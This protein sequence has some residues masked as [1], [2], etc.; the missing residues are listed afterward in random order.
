MKIVYALTSEGGDVYSQM[1][2]LSVASVRLSNP[3]A[4]VTL[5]TDTLTLGRLREKCDPLLTEVDSVKSVAAPP[6]DA[7]YRSRYV[8]TSLRSIAKGPFLFLDADTIVRDSLEP[9]FQVEADLAAAVNHS[10]DSFQEQPADDNEVLQAMEWTTG[11]DYYLN[12]GVLFF[13][14]TPAA[15]DLGRRWHECWHASV[16]RLGRHVDQPAMNHALHR[17]RAR[18]AILPHRFNAQILVAPRVAMDAAVWHYYWSFKRPPMTA[19]GVLINHFS[20]GRELALSEVQTLVARRHPWRRELWLDDAM[21]RLL[22]RKPRLETEDQLWLQGKRWEST[23]L[24]VRKAVGNTIRAVPGGRRL[25][26]LRHRAESRS[27]SSPT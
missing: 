25:L 15:H 10:K 23:R 22:H 16:T 20:K 24:R 8:K 12:T 14:D 3:R 19:Y 5:V 4:R 18:V 26:A 7:R 27:A 1:T 11:T 21:A 13:A 2:R 6:G 17:S 9:I